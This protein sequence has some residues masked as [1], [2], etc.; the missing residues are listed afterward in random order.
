VRDVAVDA[1]CLINLLAAGTILT[2]DPPT[3]PPPPRRK[4]RGPQPAPAS[5]PTPRLGYHLHVPKVAK[6]EALY[7][8][9][10]DEDDASKLVKVVI[11][12]TPL[13]DASVLFTC[14]VQGQ[15]EMDDFVRLATT[16]DDG[17]AMCLAVAKNRGWLLGT[18][19]RKAIRL[20]I[21]LGVTPV[22]TPELVK[23]WADRN[24]ATDEE[25]AAALQNIQSFARF[26]PR[27][28]SSLYAWWT[29]AAGKMKS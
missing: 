8:L 19:D 12:L 16:L 1:C 17:E 10:T 9:Q 23:H 29:D 28:N 3:A 22:T 25:L 27:R 26:V 2:L 18:D 5:Q 15:A 21:Q 13:I 20:A 11:D 4:A 6:E 24:R 14:D 7:I